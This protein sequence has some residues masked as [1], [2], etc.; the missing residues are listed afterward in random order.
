MDK[1]ELLEK[2]R[3]IDEITI[4]ELLDIN[5][6]ELIDA[7]LDKVDERLEYLYKEISN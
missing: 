5:T 4:L 3:T 1:S 7:F 6:D 2:L